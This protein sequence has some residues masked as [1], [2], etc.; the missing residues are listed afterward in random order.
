MERLPVLRGKGMSP[1]AAGERRIPLWERLF[2]RVR[3][4]IPSFYSM[5]ELWRRYGRVAVLGLGLAAGLGICLWTLGAESGMGGAVGKAPLHGGLP[6]LWGD[7]AETVTRGE[8]DTSAPSDTEAREDTADSPESDME[9]SDTYGESVGSERPTDT[10]PHSPPSE[11]SES[12]TENGA[13][14]DTS[15]VTDGE[16]DTSA[17][18]ERDSGTEAERDSGT[19]AVESDAQ[20]SDEGDPSD[21]DGTAGPSPSETMPA[22]CIP[23]CPVDMSMT[24]RGAGYVLH[25]GGSLPSALPASPLAGLESP[26]A[27]L[28]LHTHPYEGYGS[29]AD[30]YDPAE[31]SPAVTDSPHHPEGVVA[32]GSLLAEHLRER[33]ITVIHLRVAVSAEDTADEIYDRVA[34]AVADRLRLCPSIGLVLD[35][36]RSAEMTEDGGILRTAGMYGGERCAQLRLTVSGGRGEDAV[37]RDLAAALYLRRALWEASPSVSRPVRVK[38][39]EG[40]LPKGSQARLLTVEA[41]AAGNTYGEAAALMPLLGGAVEKLLADSRNYG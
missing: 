13:D 27:V 37:S 34:A 9:P 23:V 6:S 8:T 25:T 38:G 11:E 41:G 30:W 18:T 15:A 14:P 26:P 2:P 5:G 4:D 35:L 31:G 20:D 32:L 19:E 22:G 1:T 36:R 40:L 17:E 3:L 29:G 16:G 28:I 39:G 24:E 12:A 33:G 10:D 7:G 21:G